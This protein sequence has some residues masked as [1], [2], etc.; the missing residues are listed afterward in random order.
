[1]KGKIIFAILIATGLSLSVFGQTAHYIALSVGVATTAPAGQ[2]VDT[3]VQIERSTVSGGPY[4][5]LTTVPVTSGATSISYNDTSGTGG[6]T[7]YYVFIGTA[8]GATP[9]AQTAEVSATFLAPQAVGV[10]SPTA[11]AH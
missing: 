2:V 5:L 8:P 4:T 11:V 7:Y 1:M 3:A 10:T 6:V 9:S